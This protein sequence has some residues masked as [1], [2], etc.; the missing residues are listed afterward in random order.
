MIYWL[1]TEGRDGLTP[2]LFPLLCCAPIAP[3][4][5]AMPTATMSMKREGGVGE[6]A[7]ELT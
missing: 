7:T 1:F 6:G 2:L 4:I 5:T 3:L